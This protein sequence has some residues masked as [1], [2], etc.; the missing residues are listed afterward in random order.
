MTKLIPRSKIQQKINSFQKGNK[1]REKI[2]FPFDRS[3]IDDIE[4]IDYIERD[5]T[6]KEL[7]PNTTELYDK[8]R[9]FVQ[10]RDSIDMSKVIPYIQKK[11]IVL[12]HAGDLTGITLSTNL[13]DSIAKYAKI[14]N[15][16]VMKAIS[17]PATETGLGIFP[18]YTGLTPKEMNYFRNKGGSFKAQGYVT[19]TDLFNNHNYFISPERE[20]MNA[21]LKGKYHDSTGARDSYID[22]NEVPTADHVSDSYRQ[23]WYNYFNQNVEDRIKNSGKPKKRIGLYRENMDPYEHTFRYAESGRYNPGDPNWET[24]RA[25]RERELRSSPEIQEWLKSTK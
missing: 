12:T 4:G 6:M 7:Y 11:E 9:N 20:V 24:R 21:V 5:L 19:P 25:K 16:P 15:Y 3:T 14:H 22:S 23:N 10:K 18:S 2:R 17:I 8:D 1:I 13:L